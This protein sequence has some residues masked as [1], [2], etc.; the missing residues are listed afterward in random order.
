MERAMS[1]D[2]D[3]ATRHRFET[4]FANLPWVQREV[5]MLHVVDGYSYAEIAWQLRTKERSVERQ[6]ARAIYKLARQMDGHPLS[7]W[8]R[9]I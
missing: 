4:A 5:F 7:W 1:V 6:L 2:I 8:E 9:W 3:P